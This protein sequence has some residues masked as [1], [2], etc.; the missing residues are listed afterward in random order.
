MNKEKFMKELENLT[1]LDKE[2]CIM[3]NTIL[4]DNFIIGKK[5][6]EKIVL[7]IA[8]QLDLTTTEAEEIYE[9]SMSII[10]DGIKDKLK[11]PFKNQD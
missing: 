3:I 1:G 10:G 11:H 5:K 2:Q 9:S 4:E 7:E 6:K 8:K